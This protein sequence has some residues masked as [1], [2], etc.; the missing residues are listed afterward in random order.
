MTP[1]RA[2]RCKVDARRSA[3]G[4]V[5]A[6]AGL[7]LAC[8]A[9][10]ASIEVGPDTRVAVPLHSFKAL[11]DDRVVKQ[12]FDYSCGAAALATLLTYAFADP[13]TEDALVLDLLRSLDPNEEVLRRK[14]GF[15]L[16]DL[17]KVAQQRGYKAQGFRIAPEFVAALQG[18]VIVFIKPRGYPHFAILKGVRGGRVYLAD[19]SLGN[20]RRSL[21]DFFDIWLGDDGK[22]V[23][24]AVEPRQGGFE[25][26]LLHLPPHDLPRPELMSV[27][28]LMEVGPSRGSAALAR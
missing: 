28:Q 1:S 2:W 27:R 3:W 12:A 16:L 13:V 24:F 11:R 22:G 20:V 6:V 19:P 8:A 10:A 15:S 5:S 9:D 21:A 23:I 4:G 7:L 26:S 25:H 14:Q 17:Q 18:A